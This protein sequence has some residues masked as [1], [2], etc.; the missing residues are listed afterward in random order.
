ML[1]N[2]YEDCLTV[3]QQHFLENMMCNAVN[4]NWSKEKDKICILFAKNRQ[5]NTDHLRVRMISA[6]NKLFLTQ[7]ADLDHSIV[8]RN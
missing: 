4:I 6:F 3:S 7:L 8:N 1:T 5:K 2:N